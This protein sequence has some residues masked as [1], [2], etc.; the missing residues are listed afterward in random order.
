[1]RR[2]KKF[3]MKLTLATRRVKMAIVGLEILRLALASSGYRQRSAP[4]PAASAF[5]VY[6]YAVV[7]NLYICTGASAKK[8]FLSFF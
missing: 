4:R 8:S 1:M 3:G 7:N 2:K 5:I 6:F